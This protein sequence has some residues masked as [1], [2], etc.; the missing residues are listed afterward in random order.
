[1]VLILL[2]VVDGAD[3]AAGVDAVNVVDDFFK[4]TAPQNHF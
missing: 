1:M 3:S 4:V 2:V